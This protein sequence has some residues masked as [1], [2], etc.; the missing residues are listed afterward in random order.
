MNKS[1]IL[2]FVV[3]VHSFCFSQTTGSHRGDSLYGAGKWAKAITAYKADIKQ[4]ANLD[5]SP[6]VW[7]RLGFAYYKL[8]Q[9]D[10]ANR[11]YIKSDS[12]MPS[13][14]L[15]PVLYSKMARL[16]ALKNNRTEMIVYLKK[17]VESGY[18]LFNEMD[19]LKE[20]KSFKADTE[21]KQLREKAY[22]AAYPCSIDPKA[23]QFDFWVGE[24]DA[25]QTGTNML[26]GH[27]VIQ[28]AS[29]GCMILE[30]WTSASQPYSGKSMNFIDKA[31]GKW[32]Q[33]W[34]GAE[35]G[36]EHIFTNGTYHDSAMHFDFEDSGKNGSKIKGRFT[37]F[38]EGPNKV[39]QLNETSD[40][41][42][43]TWTTAYDL[44]Y[45]RKKKTVN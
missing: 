10:N 32:E 31:S 11:S 8:G 14:A 28:I 34:V 38:N 3:C 5:K 35:G 24:W 21:F 45:I 4:T 9:Y 26:A 36:G 2:A 15:K 22:A 13:A 23:R 18:V 16:F 1:I 44:T 41:A 33:V 30:N 7:Y 6:L 27:S 19:T 12:L 43:K 20:F 25:Y 42:G 37:F 39:R 29:G 40:D 17:A